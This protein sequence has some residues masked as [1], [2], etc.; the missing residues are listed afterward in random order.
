MANEYYTHGSYPSAFSFGSSAQMRAELD[1]ITTGFDKLPALT[2]NAYKF[3]FINSTGNGMT[4]SASLC[5]NAAGD[6]GIGTN[7][8]AVVYNRNLALV[9]AGSA[10]ISFGSGTR[11]YAIGGSG[12]T[13]QFYDSTAAAVRIHLDSS[14]N[15]GVGTTSPGSALDVKGTLRL[16]GSS[17]GYVGFSSAAIAG[18]T[19]YTL[20]SAD[21]TSGQV[22]QTN[23][24]ATLSWV[25]PSSGSGI[26][27]FTS[28]LDT[29]APNAT[30][31]YAQLLAAN[32]SYT[33]IDVAYTPKGNGA[34]SL[35]VADNTI[36]G[37]NKRGANAV[38]LQVFNRTAATQVASG[39]VSFTAGSRN[40]ASTT[41]C[42]AIG[43]TNTA[44]GLR[45]IA[46]GS[47]NTATG[48]YSVA[49]GSNNT[50][51]GQYSVVLSAWGTATTNSLYGAIVGGIYGNTRNLSGNLVFPSA[52]GTTSGARQ[53]TIVTLGLDTTDATV[54]YLTSDGIS[55]VNSATTNIVLP[56][57]SAFY[58]KG[59]IVAGVTAGGNTKGWTIEGVA[60]RGATAATVAFVGTPT[61]TSSYADAGASTWTIAVSANTTIG[62]FNIVATGQAAT[63][64]RWVGTIQVVEMT[65]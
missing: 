33:S 3:P 32:A 46:I 13:L 35:Q 1:T 42:V 14:G 62:G 4:A 34:F 36:S 6:V 2:G 38:D 61:V 9:G 18:S 63:N 52:I 57:N 40:T 37:G 20:P 24:T 27:N 41:N 15:V 47:N 49:I 29:T 65:Y 28:N 7:S 51:I 59:T 16:S 8:P 26:A 12:G 19:T 23:G 39:G 10:G 21:G 17:S 58:F 64:I 56:N 48:Q 50:A 60:K 30:I 44:D 43:Y 25:T 45:S 11:T 5:T 31:P 53:L 22:L 55:A 54:S